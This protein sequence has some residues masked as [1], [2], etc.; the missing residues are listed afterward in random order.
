M[1]ATNS[2]A[3]NKG[4]TRFRKTIGIIAII[5]GLCQ[6]EVNCHLIISDPKIRELFI[7]Y[8]TAF[9]GAMLIGTGIVL[10]RQELHRGS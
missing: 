5:L 1:S 2:T 9:S 7:W 3:A 10:Q 4:R 6:V 8:V